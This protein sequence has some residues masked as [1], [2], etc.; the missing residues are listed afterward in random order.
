MITSAAGGADGRATT[1][2]VGKGFYDHHSE[3]Q[4]A[5]LGQQEARLRNAARQVSLGGLD[6]RVTD[7][8]CGPGRNSIAA[9]RT[10]LQEIRS[11]TRAM[12]V[13]ANHNDQLGNDWTQLFADLRGPESYLRDADHVRTEV[14][15]GSFFDSVA[16]NGMVDLGMCFG[17][18]HWL[19]RPVEIAS[20][21]TLFFCDLAEPARSALTA[22][23]YDDWTGFLRRRRD[24]LRPGG[25]FVVD[26]LG[27]VSD[28]D[29]PSGVRAAGRRLYRAFWQVA[30]GLA[31]E[32]RID[33][34]LLDR[35]VF[36]VYF[37]LSEEA[38]GPIEQEA[39]LRGAFEI[40]ESTNDLLPMP[41]EDVLA[42]T[43]DATA[44]AA[45][46]AGFARAFAEPTLRPQLFEPSTR[47]QGE[48][49]RL[50]EDFF[51]RLQALFAA[52]PGQ[53]GF[54]HQVVTLVLR[55]NV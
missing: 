52:E 1:G 5:G 45:S 18:A 21:G 28:P 8:G 38:L 17:A 26:M 34:A 53:H 9:F 31:G 42:R 33:R 20:P 51:Q 41:Y 48:A 39:D 40:V 55:K 15:I 11:R 3:A 12:P 47:T 6:L 50:S 43:G 44:Y 37:R 35:F 4:A 36:P 13:V 27:S 24:E 14:S 10:I 54:E 49:D 19:A 22:A 46:Y 32:G 29:D 2:M 16:S 23:A 25:W 7:Y 30:D